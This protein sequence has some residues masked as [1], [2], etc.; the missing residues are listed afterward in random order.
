MNR[1]TNAAKGAANKTRTTNGA[2]AYKSTLSAN[3]DFFSSAGALRSNPQKAV[4]LFKAAFQE[5]P[6]LALRNALWVRDVRGG[7][8]ERRIAREALVEL[9]RTQPDLYLKSNL[10]DKVVEVGRWDD[11]LHVYQNG[12]NATIQSRIIQKIRN[13]L[14]AGDGLCAKWMPR[15]GA[16]AVA[17]RTQLGMSP[18]QYRKT[19]VSLTNVVETQMCNREWEAIEYRKVP[20]QAMHK[21]AKAF[22]KHTP[23]R[24]QAFL[25]KVTSG[26]ETIKAE[27][28]HPH[29]LVSKVFRGGYGYTT[30]SDEARVVDAQWKALP[31]YIQGDHGILPMCDV[32]GSMSVGIGGDYTSRVTCM[33]AAIALSIYTAERNRGAFQDLVLTFSGNPEFHAL[34]GATLEDRV[35][36][37]SR[38]GWQMNTNIERAYKKILVTALENS[39]PQEDMPKYLVI[40]SDMQFDNCVQSNR[41]V[42]QD[43]RAMYFAAG[44]EM[45]RV[46]FWNLNA[47]YGN[48]PVTQHESGAALVSG[49]SP[50]LMKAIL[51]DNLEQFTPEAVMLETLMSERY[52][53][54]A[55]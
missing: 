1:F 21:H 15:K 42:L 48:S 32:S 8:G 10:I 19:L 13:A 27:T 30:S 31:D 22:W 6:E 47:Q 41:T 35:N 24:M 17:L 5:S 54:Q 26:E 51:S 20:S 36:N 37:L 7:A 28:L 16:L 12:R 46:V 45:P 34:H 52:S 43:I 23:E 25:N 40:F 44:Y 50:S 4:S 29:Q 14:E 55:A 2:A 9:A 18:K 3:L 38:A 53:L 49:F 39:V 11:L 33:H